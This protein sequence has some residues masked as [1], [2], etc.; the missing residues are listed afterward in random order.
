MKKYEAYWP[1]LNQPSMII[2]VDIGTTSVK[3]VQM[4]YQDGQWALL[5]IAHVHIQPD[6][7]DSKPAILQVL[8]DS[9]AGMDLDGSRIVCVANCPQTCVRTMTAPPMPSQELAEAIRWEARNYVSFPLEEAILDYEITG[10]TIE[11]GV[12]KLNI[13]VAAS[14]RETIDRLLSFFSE[15]G[16]KVSGIIPIFAALQ[17]VV[18]RSQ[19]KSASSETLAVIE[20]GASITELNIY[21]NARLAFSRK[22]STAGKNITESLM[23]TLVSDHGKLQLNFQQAEEIK[24]K[25][26]MIESKTDQWIEEKISTS[27]IL[28][29]IRP[30]LEQL[31]SDIESSLDFYR[32]ESRG[33]TVNRILLFGG[34]S[35][36]LGLAPFLS[37]QLGIQVEVGHPL[38]WIKA[39]SDVHIQDPSMTGLFGMAI[40]AAVGEAKGSGSSRAKNINLLPVELKEETKRLVENVSL[41]AVMT[42]VV[43]MAGLFYAG[44]RIQASTADKKFQAAQLEY[45]GLQS[46][47]G[48]LSEKA[49]I[50]HLV[51]DHP[52]WEEIF[53]ELSNVL[54]AGMYLT[55]LGI[56]DN[57]ISFKG[58][59]HQNGPDMEVALSQFMLALENG[60]FKN[61]QLI[62][63]QKLDSSSLE[64]EV[65]GNAE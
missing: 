6:G 5:K 11:K 64:F 33:G 10:E 43:V 15:L 14:P 22:L 58:I 52:A 60:I 56:E 63:T 59:I 48:E 4:S 8:K 38:E 26:G 46:Q 17:N 16:I 45:Q 7:N 2:G 20:C 44:M 35:S 30:K 57:T 40:G 9:L 31:V 61:V 54:P 23:T 13:T 19:M 28:S 55:E 53:R 36:L 51:H 1:R 29:L 37:Q 65:S 41:K 24:Q 42:A 3:V 32:E 25:Y 21:R 39:P 62:K 12:K 34:G 18:H 50:S 49:K 27:Q 47:I